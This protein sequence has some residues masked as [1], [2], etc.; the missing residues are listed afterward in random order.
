MSIARPPR[1]RCA[2]L[3]AAVLWALAQSALAQLPQ[4][5]PY[6]VTLRNYLA[7]LTEADF[8]IDLKPYVYSNAFTPDPDSLFAHWLWHENRTFGLPAE[9]R[10]LRVPASA[11]VLTNIESSGE[12]R[13]RV[14]RSAFF[15]PVG[16][17]W[18][19]QWP[20]PG[21]PHRPGTTNALAARRRAFVGAAV[22]LM[23]LDAY[24]SQGNG[25][26]SDY[27]GGSLIRQAYVYG[28]VKSTLPPEVQA[29]YESGLRR[30]FERIEGVYPGAN[31][32]AD[33]ET[34][35][36]VGLWYA[37]EA[38]GD[39]NLRSRALARSHAVLDAIIRPA[40]YEHHGYAFDSSYMGIA[41]RFMTWAGLLYRDPR[42]SQTLDGMLRLKAYLNL[43]EPGSTNYD[44]VYVGPSHFNTGTDE[45]AVKDQW[46]LNFR[47]TGDAMQSDEALH[48]MVGGRDVPAY[49]KPLGYSD[50]PAM[51]SD[52]AG[53]IDSVNYGYY[54][55]EGLTTPTAA[56]SAVWSQNY[57]NEG[58][59]YAHDFTPTGFWNRLR[60]LRLEGSPLTLPP[61]S[62]RPD[63]VRAFADDFLM[64]KMGNYGAIIHADVIR[65]QWNGHVAGLS[66]G[67]L[68]AFWT[69]VTGTVLLGL[70]GGSQSTAS[71]ETW[72]G[73][74]N[75]AVHAI[76]G[77]DAAGRPFS[78]ARNRNP[79]A[80]F[81]LYGQT[82]AVATVSGTIGTNDAAM[83]APG[84]AITG[85]VSYAR[86]FTC[87]ATGLTV[88]TTLASD[89]IDAVSELWEI[90]P[91]HLRAL[92]Q[93]T[94]AV[95]EFR[96][97][98]SWTPASSA[99]ATNISRVRITRFGESVQIVFDAPQRVRMSPAITNRSTSYTWNLM[100]DM[101]G[102][103]VRPT[104]LPA[105]RTV[106]YVIL[107]PQPRLKI[108]GLPADYGAPK[109]R[110]YGW[111]T[112]LAYNT[113]ITNRV[114]HVYSDTN[115]FRHLCAG[116]TLATN[117]VFS[118]SG[119]TTQ[120]V[121]RLNT[122]AVLTWLWTNVY[123][124]TLAPCT[125]G[126]ISGAAGWRAG[127][128]TT[129]L[130]A[131][132][133]PYYHL[134]AW[135]G[136]VPAGSGSTNPLALLMD[137]PRTVTA[138]FAE[139]VSP[140]GVPERW[141]AGHGLTNFPGDETGDPDADGQETWQEYATGTNPTNA[142]S[143]FAVNPAATPLADGGLVVR[144]SSAT[145][146]QYRVER[147]TNLE[148]GFDRVLQSGIQGR[149]PEN[150][151]TDRTA[152]AFRELFFRVVTELTP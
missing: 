52:I 92:P 84:G 33:M 50:Q 110:G 25:V 148:A 152:H 48:L 120:A 63:F 53:W 117:G 136:D 128:S 42:I 133:A 51:R 116:W 10:G 140:H 119:T 138:A 118:Q 134:A 105:S 144:W 114:G 143:V 81:E 149:P 126:S 91:I 41:L 2:L 141:L 9:H 30:L 64:V 79:S 75:W 147:A 151:Y 22:D 122:N 76:S 28:I 135:G 15:D 67:S 104:P 109:S 139:N 124:L 115:G 99:L 127:D 43:P 86:V 112:N 130:S 73:W 100:I 36:I 23:M 61:F 29:A 37:A 89:Q 17:A 82:A 21:N 131:V 31:S 103:V 24:N 129:A 69:P 125:N 18:W 90:L 87:T 54:G 13:M 93:T 45:S 80:T 74:S 39:D 35:Q 7:T 16:I 34:F 20:F 111:H 14:G 66:G 121:F 123:Q 132:S 44:G 137:R 94:N 62:R 71:Y 108:M 1:A 95:V 57:W 68:S 55:D 59:N 47:D 106:A 12:V 98:S 49:M 101:L 96:A 72:S 77:T 46:Y 58:I 102:D 107:P 145:G 150:T 6:Q 85:S 56:V 8:A 27:M 3:A 5:Q 19:S 65:D 146:R 32:G 97:G 113:W 70:N 142:R 11:F 26:R 88:R 60:L 38:I 40:G 4:S 83:S 78:S